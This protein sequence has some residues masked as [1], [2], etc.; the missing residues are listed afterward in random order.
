MVIFL[1]SIHNAGVNVLHINADPETVASAYTVRGIRP[2]VGPGII[3]LRDSLRLPA[4]CVNT[5]NG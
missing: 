2:V 1:I 5:R 4:N 3:S